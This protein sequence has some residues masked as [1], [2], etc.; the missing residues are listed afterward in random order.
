MTDEFRGTR[1]SNLSRRTG[2]SNTKAKRTGVLEEDIENEL[3]EP[4][5]KDIDPSNLDINV[6][7]D[8]I[9]PITSF[10]KGNIFENA[11][12]WHEKGYTIFMSADIK[13]KNQ[14]NPAFKVTKKDKGFR[15]ENADQ[16]LDF[17]FI[18]LRK[19]PFHIGCCYNA[20]LIYMHKRMNANAQKW[21]R[22][23]R[24]LEPDRKE[25]YLG[26]AI[27]SLKLNQIKY[28]IRVLRSRPG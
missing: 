15:Y 17:Y 4:S 8:F 21:F 12:Y 27:S 3:P 11:D 24:R 28:A 26:E 14:D 16:A 25:A 9:E 13:K 23:T 6:I 19:N 2:V 7:L 1:K 22:I 10:K 18:G 5:I 20:A